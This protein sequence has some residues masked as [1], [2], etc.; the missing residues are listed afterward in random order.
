VNI[1]AASNMTTTAEGVQQE[2][3]RELLRELGCTEMQGNLFSPA[4]PAADV[5]RLLLSHRDRAVSAA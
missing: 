3:Q 5:R 4:I 1:A 2:W